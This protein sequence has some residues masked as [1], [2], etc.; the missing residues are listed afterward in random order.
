LLELAKKPKG[1]EYLFDLYEEIRSRRRIDPERGE[2]PLDW[3]ELAAWKAVT[4]HRVRGWDIRMIGR[5][6]DGYFGAKLAAPG[7]FFGG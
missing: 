4:E 1:F 3:I 5:I 6:D 7:K 2:M